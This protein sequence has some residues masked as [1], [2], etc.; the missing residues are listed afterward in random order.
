MSS[1]EQD[2]V[3]LQSVPPATNVSEVLVQ[4]KWNDPPI[5]KWRMLAT[6]IT[7]SLVGASDGV[8]GVLVPSV[9]ISFASFHTPRW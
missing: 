1:K 2:A 9:R 3:E 4:Q 7:F 8:Y 5:N 6:F